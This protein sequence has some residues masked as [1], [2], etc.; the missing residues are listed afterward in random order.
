MTSATRSM[1]D[2]VMRQEQ[3]D[4]IYDAMTMTI[5][6]LKLML[7]DASQEDIRDQS[8]LS[9]PISASVFRSS[10]NTSLPG[11]KGY[12]KFVIPSR[13]KQIP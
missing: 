11:Y 2:L 6:L 12:S 4:S 8:L 13:L 10:Y 3:W 1:N 7:S 5:W 9:V